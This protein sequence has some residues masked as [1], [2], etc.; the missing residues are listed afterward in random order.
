M[1]SSCYS[2]IRG[3]TRGISPE[4]GSD[5]IKRAGKD[6]VLM[7]Y[8]TRVVFF[9]VRRGPSGSSDLSGVVPLLM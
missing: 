8:T 2:N 3:V 1:Y 9:T 7:G 6:L 4:V 5:D